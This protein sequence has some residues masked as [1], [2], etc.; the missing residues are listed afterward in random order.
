LIID[1][2]NRVVVASLEI[3]NYA[4]IRLVMSFVPAGLLHNLLRPDRLQSMLGNRKLSS[5]VRGTVSG[6]L[7]PIS[8]CGVSWQATNNDP[9]FPPGTTPSFAHVLSGNPAQ[10]SFLDSR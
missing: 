4:S 2:L 7:L 9:G 3:L 10:R 8:S 1:V 5:I 6:M